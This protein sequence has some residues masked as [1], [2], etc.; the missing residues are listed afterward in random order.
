M[1]IVIFMILPI[2]SFSAQE[3]VDQLRIQTSTPK[4]TADAIFSSLIVW[5]EEESGAEGKAKGLTMIDSS[6][7]EIETAQIIAKSLN[8]GIN[9]GAPSARGAIANYKENQAVFVINNKAGFDLTKVLISDYSN[10]KLQYNLPEKKFN[11]AGVD[12][13]IDIVPFKVVENV[14][15]VLPKITE[16]TITLSVDNNLPTVISTQGKNTEQLEMELSKALSKF[17]HF[18][19]EPLYPNIV[20]LK[21][22]N[23]REFDNG[24]IQFIGLDAKY[25]SIEVNDS[26]LGVIT[27]FRFPAINKKQERGFN[28]S[29][30][31]LIIFLL[32][33]SLSY[34]FY[35]RKK[36]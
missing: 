2:I 28:N 15:V 21:S 32:L 12:I 3:G 10:Q 14:D 36:G 11:D 7:T 5:R 18:S 27:K 17:S 25:I 30:I 9:Y 8:A 24:E 29:I 16:G 1:V 34:V 4:R 13:A 31:K 26:T 23:Y 35:A 6:K 19:S 20:E 22:R 33:A